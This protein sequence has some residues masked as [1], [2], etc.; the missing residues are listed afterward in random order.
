[1]KRHLIAAANAL[2]TALLSL[3]WLGTGWRSVAAAVAGA[4]ATYAL[5]VWHYHRRP[6]AEGS[7]SDA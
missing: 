1:M 2:V 5:T 3:W 6:P 4:I 7:A